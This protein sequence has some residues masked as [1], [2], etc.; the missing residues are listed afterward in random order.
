MYIKKIVDAIYILNEDL[1]KKMT[2][3]NLILV[4]FLIIRLLD[5]Y[6]SVDCCMMFPYN[7]YLINIR[8]FKALQTEF[9]YK[10]K[11]N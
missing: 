4:I 1:I 2:I 5:N 9:K 7:S 8:I 10:I 3:K 11:M 6:I